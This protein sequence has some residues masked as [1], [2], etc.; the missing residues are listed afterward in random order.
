MY[1]TSTGLLHAVSVMLYPELV[2][3][4][5]SI[6]CFSCLLLSN[7]DKFNTVK[8]VSSQRCSY[9]RLVLRV[10]ADDSAKLDLKVLILV[11]LKE[12]PAPRAKG[13]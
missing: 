10:T 2:E 11:H 12:F 4:V 8:E 13:S 7:S 3:Y 5:F 6:A 1:L 9:R